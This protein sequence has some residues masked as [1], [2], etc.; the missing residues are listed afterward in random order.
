M[1]M[2]TVITKKIIEQGGADRFVRVEQLCR[3]IDGSAKRRYG[4]V[5][6]ALKSG[7]LVRLQRGLYIMAD[8]YRNH[9]PHPFALAQALVPGSYI[10]FETALSFHGWIPEKVFTTS[11]V[12]PSRKSRRYEH[13]KLGAYS[14]HPLAVQKGFFLE[15]VNRHQI[16]GQTMLVA[17]PCRALIDLVCLRKIAWQNIGWISEGLRI[18]F[19]FLR[20]ITKEDINTLQLVYKHKQVKAFLSSLCLELHID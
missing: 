5:N 3:L 20:S 4:L 17:K 12:V 13:E 1:S 10:S 18:D 19:D 11:S 9:H 8:R 14:F 15:L 2:H 16:D 7:E 6:R